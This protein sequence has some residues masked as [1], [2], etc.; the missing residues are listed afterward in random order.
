MFGHCILSH[1]SL[2]TLHTPMCFLVTVVLYKSRGSCAGCRRSGCKW[3][4]CVGGEMGRPERFMVETLH[5]CSQ[6][7]TLYKRWWNPLYLSSPVFLCF[8]S[9]LPLHTQIYCFKDLIN[10][11]LYENTKRP[12]W[13]ILPHVGVLF[14]IFLPSHHPHHLTHLSQALSFNG[15]LIN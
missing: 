6:G 4:G 12:D 9:I 10:R 14:F 7:R 2:C 15:L 13:S 1:I 5:S 8:W 11:P 3:V